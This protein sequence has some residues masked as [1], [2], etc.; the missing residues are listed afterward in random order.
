M[1]QRAPKSAQAAGRTGINAERVPGRGD[2]FLREGLR[3][4]ARP[5]KF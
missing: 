4:T 1:G 3:R 5:L 2:Y